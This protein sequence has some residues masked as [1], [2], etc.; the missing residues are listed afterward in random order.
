MARQRPYIVQ[1]HGNNAVGLVGSITGP[2]GR[3]GANIELAQTIGR[4]G[5]F[6]LELLTD[7][8]QCRVPLPNLMASIE[9]AMG[10]LGM[11]TIF[12]T[13]DVFNKKKRIILFDIGKSLID[14]TL[15]AEIVKQTGLD[16]Q[17][18]AGTC[19]AADEFASLRHDAHA[20]GR[21]QDHHHHRSRPGPWP[22]RQAGDDRDPWAFA[23]PVHG[24]EGRC[25]RRGLLAGPAH[26]GH[27]PAFYRGSAEPGGAQHRRRR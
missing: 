3:A 10:A 14:P 2:I 22:D 16:P 17:Q 20:D 15:R 23:R 4:E 25:R 8:S 27:Q 6:L 21:G 7:V 5:L 9:E 13:E 24:D 19:S 11:K 26:G 12:Q 18:V 1:G